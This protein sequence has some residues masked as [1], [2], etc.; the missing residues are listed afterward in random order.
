GSLGFSCIDGHRFIKA[1]PHLDRKASHD[2][3]AVTY[4]GRLSGGLDFGLPCEFNLQIFDA[5]DIGNV[6]NNAF[7]E[8]GACA[9]NL[10]VRRHNSLRIRNEAGIKV[11]RE[12]FANCQGTTVT[13]VVGLKWVYQNPLSGRH[14]RASFQHQHKSF[15]LKTRD[16]ITNQIAPEASITLN[17]EDGLYFSAYYEGA[18]GDGWKSN[19]VGLHLGKS[20]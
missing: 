18:F 20:F 3:H 2:N 11:F 7:K 8:H 16:S 6:H 4:V 15:K 1:G 5:F 9:L 12:F 13:P 14:V 19:E 17:S 10:H